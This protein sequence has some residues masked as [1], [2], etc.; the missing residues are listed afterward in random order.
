MQVNIIYDQSVGSLPAG[1][2]AAVNYVV[3]YFDTTFTNAVTVNIDL[4]YGEVAGQS[5]GSGALGESETYFDS[6]S[7]TQ[8]VNALKANQPSLTQQAAYATLP[9]STPLSGGTMWVS[10]AEQKALGLL[11]GNNSAIDGYIGLSSTYPFSYAANTTPAAGQYYF[12]GVLAHELSEVLGRSSM[13]GQGLGGTTSYTAMDLFR[14]SAPGTRQLGTGG[15][16]YFSINN[17]TTNL[18]SWNTNPGG[19]LG[20]WA[21][22]AGTDSFL[23]FS[24]SG[25]KDWITQPDLTLMNVLGWDMATAGG[26]SVTATAS[27]AVQ[28]GASVTLLAG[29][30]TITDQASST[31]ASATVKVTNGVGSA[32]VG[33]ELYING[34]QS[35]AVSG[36]AV[37]VSWND[38]TKVLTLTGTASIATYDT[39][40]SQV[41]YKSTG[42]DSS[43][44]GHPQ[45]TVSWTVNDGSTNL[46]TTSQI[47]IDRAPVASNDTG[48]DVVGVALSVPASG[49]VLA[50]DTDLDGDTL[51]VSSVSDTAHGAGV[52]GNSLAGVYGHLTLNADGSYAYTAD[53]SAAINGAPT[54]SHL[55]DVFSYTASDGK[56]GTSGAITLNITLDRLPV[57]TVANL[58]ASPGQAFQATSLFQASEPD[59]DAITKY[60][61][62]DSGTGGAHFLLNGVAQAIGQ[63]IDVTAAQLA[64]VTYRPGPG[65][66]TVQIRAYGGT[67]WSRWSSFTVTAPMDT[68]PVLTAPDKTVAHNSAMAAAALFTVSDPFGDPMTAYQFYDN[69]SDPASGHF[70]L[71]GVA[72]GAIQTISVTAAQLSQVSFQSGSGTDDLYVRATDDGTQWSAWTGFHVTAPLDTGPVVTAADKTV[73]HNA[74]LAA[75]SLFTTSDP[76]GDPMTVYQL[77]DTTTDPASG[78]F[79]VNGIVQG[80]LQVINVTAAQLSQ[81]SF[82]S[83][84]GTDDLWVRAS[85]NG[86]QWSAWTEFHVTALVDTSLVV[87][88]I[89]RTVTHDANPAAASL[90]TAIDSLGDPMTAYQLYDNTADPLSG[91]FVVDG[92]VQG[93]LQVISLTAAQLSQTSFR[94][95]MGTDDLLV[96]ASNDGTQWSAWTEFHVTAPVDTGPVVTATSRTTVANQSFAASSLFA[97][98]DP[99][100]DPMTVYQLYD[101][102]TDLLSGSFMVNGVAQGALQV[103]S[104]TA[105]QLSQTSFRSGSASDDLWLRASDN[106]TQW[107]AWTEFQVN[108]ASSAMISSGGTLE[109][110]SAFSG[111]A[112]YAG[113]TGTLKIDTSSSFTGTI[114]GQLAIGDVIDLADITAGASAT[115]GYTGNNSPGMLTVSD[116]THTASI[117]LLGNYSLA[118]FAASSDGHGG[119]SVVDPPLLAGQAGGARSGSSAAGTDGE[120]LWNR[121]MGLLAQYMASFDPSSWGEVGAPK[122]ALLA[123]DTGQASN[124]THPFE[125]RQHG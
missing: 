84:V 35:G 64:Q 9:G 88:A 68:G 109:L 31:I 120:G 94:S 52:V 45:R 30:P 114:A 105:A 51:T 21:G 82:Q 65:A 40:L 80:S 13:L 58:S 3:N 79:V 92:V 38:I 54:G 24:P 93:A 117:A 1:F 7:Y 26:I 63:E 2:V 44:G 77:Y 4:G 75:T 96:R 70:V 22:S 110:G 89:D 90:F 8:V 16:A 102:S 71:N 106:G 59:G 103:T 72:Q 20:D 25:Q 36:G 60:A 10:T 124:L 67:Q 119:T 111:T 112:T 48:A 32:I 86:T 121:N 53:I 57:V 56:G 85:D 125:N 6:F 37:T 73:A 107:S 61:F 66:D 62:L 42:T 108:V 47:A 11:A 99:F 97:V 23:A 118:S 12:E 55:H 28:G 78:S 50:N 74:N 83:G 69:T 95:G 98:S 41:A 17:G 116:G 123:H 27:E 113:S 104:V 14:Y 81:T 122:G 91:S 18:D 33:D 76:L 49:G 87:T 39:L 100:G 34:Q 29:A 101:N 43:S 19:D 5:L 46:S 115:I 15:P